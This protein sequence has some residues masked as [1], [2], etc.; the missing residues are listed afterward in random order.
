M[1]YVKADSMSEIYGLAKQHD[2]ELLEAAAQ[3]DSAFGGAST[4]NKKSKSLSYNDQLQ[5]MLHQDV[6]H[7]L[8]VV[9]GTLILI[10]VQSD[11][12]SRNGYLSI[13]LK[14]GT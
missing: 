13:F 2:P 3:R 14:N 11:I 8:M 4:R 10:G 5:G 6:D 7:E 12:R 1:I 9:L